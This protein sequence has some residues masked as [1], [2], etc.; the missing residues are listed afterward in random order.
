MAE[1]IRKR[2]FASKNWAIGKASPTS[3][4]CLYLSVV[5]SFQEINGELVSGFEVDLCLSE[6]RTVRCLLGLVKKRSWLILGSFL[7]DFMLP[8][9]SRK[10][11]GDQQKRR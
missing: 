4:R 9:F 3:P 11:A 1:Q 8:S 2:S 5:S 6:F 10:T 7:S